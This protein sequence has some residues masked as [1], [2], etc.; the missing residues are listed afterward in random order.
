[1]SKNKV[2]FKLPPLGKQH[3]KQAMNKG[4]QQVQNPVTK[5]MATEQITSMI[6]QSGIPPVMFVQIGRLAEIAIRDPKRY[7]EFANFMVKHKLETPESVKK[8]DYQMLAS[9]A[10][11]G[12]VAE[13]FAKPAVKAFWDEYGTA[14]ES[15]TKAQ[16]D[17][18]PE[19]IALAKKRLEILAPQFY[20]KYS[21]SSST[22]S[23][24]TA[25]L[26]LLSIIGYNI[27]FIC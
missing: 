17:K 22:T 19:A 12:K 1:M 18:A 8:P 7:H 26:F 11:I 13:T 10:V 9:M 5:D 6:N 25:L 4:M 2:T 16:A 27:A 23:A 20:L 14:L 24:V 15:L 3:A 21:L